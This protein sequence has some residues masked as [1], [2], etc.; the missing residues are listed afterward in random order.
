MVQRH[1]LHARR[2]PWTASQRDLQAA[3]VL[4]HLE[5]DDLVRYGLIPEFI[6]RMP[7]SAVLEPLDES[8]LQSILTEPRD[9]LVKQFRTLPS[10]D[11]VQLQFADDAIE[12]IAQE[13]HRRKTG[14]RALRG[15][16][17]LMLD[18][19]TTFPP[20]QRE[21]VHHHPGDGGG[22]HRWQ[23]APLAWNGTT[24]DRLSPWLPL[25]TSRCRVS[26][27][28]SIITGSISATEPLPTTWRGV[29]SCGA[30]WTTSARGNRCV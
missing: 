1:R 30:P 29:K 24:E 3:Q 23:G 17:E 11:N 16:V 28:C 21:R 10:M 12:A 27:A 14:A 20:K 5:P 19:C 4:R 25:T 18:R 9:A 2:W 15:I 6:G 26:T 13:A 7:V 8:A 22:T